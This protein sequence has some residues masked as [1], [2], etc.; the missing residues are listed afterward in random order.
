MVVHASIGGSTLRVRLSNEFG[1]DSI[2]IGAAHVALQSSGSTIVA[3]SDRT[4]T[5]GGV[6]AVAMA[7]GAPVVSDPID[8]TVP[9]LGN[10]VV[11]IYL[12]QLTQNQTF[13]ALGQQPPYLS[14]GGDST[15]ATI[16][17][18]AT[19]TTS[20]YLLSA[21]EVI[22]SSRS[23]A[24]ATLG[25]SITD[26]YA[27]TVNANHRWP[28]V[29]AERLQ[30]SPRFSDVAVIDEGISGNRLLHDAI[31][32][33]ALS[34]LD[35]DVVANS[36]VEFMTLLEGINDLGF[37]G[38]FGV[39]DQAVTADYIIRAYRQIITRAHAHRIRVYGATLTPFEGTVF[40]GYY[41]AEGE[42]KREAVNSWIRTSGAFDAV[43]DFDRV[44]RDPSHPTRILPAFDSGDHLHPN[45]AGYR[46]MG[47][48]IDLSL[49]DGD[50]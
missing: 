32:P 9:P 38:A 17:P 2:Y 47:E 41:T 49:F 42:A 11:T 30:A 7:K 31:G 40:P 48:A 16:F 45:D 36:G 18:T 27:S 3:G 5:F 43:I 10:V 28:N 46:A 25:D 8:L 35:R 34:R 20:Y 23:V 4:L 26:G 24:V 1:S 19:T 44:V 37:P 13:H 33:D 39:A 22:G 15:N 6:G 14:A 50:R 21:V 29:L 12:P